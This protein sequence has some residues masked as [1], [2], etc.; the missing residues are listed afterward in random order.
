MKT[1]L[2]II[3][4]LLTSLMA[5]NNQP[6]APVNHPIALPAI[7]RESA[8]YEYRIEKALV[9]MHLDI[10]GDSVTGNLSY[11][12]AEKDNNTGT[13]VGVFKG[14]TLFAD[15]KFLSEGKESVREVAFLRNGDKLVEGHAEAIENGNRM[16]FKDTSQLNFESNVILT[17]VACAE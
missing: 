6:K 3:A 11:N 13:L 2:T 10:I 9:L 12:F 15:Y 4:I 8:C 17:K 16:S 5:C 1:Q 7:E 14:D